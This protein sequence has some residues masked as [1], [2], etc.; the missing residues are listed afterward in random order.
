VDVTHEGSEVIVSAG[1]VGEG[2]G[3][4]VRLGPHSGV[5]VR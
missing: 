5:V 1:T 3:A 4:T 2:E